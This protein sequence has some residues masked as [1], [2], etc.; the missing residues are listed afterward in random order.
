MKSGGGGEQQKKNYLNLKFEKF[1][2]S[3]KNSKKFCDQYNI[4]SIITSNKCL[5]GT[6]RVAELAKK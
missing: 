1:K 5:T 4:K 3:W 6:D 2:K